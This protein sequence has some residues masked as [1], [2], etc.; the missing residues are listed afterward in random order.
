M[1]RTKPGSEVTVT[2]EILDEAGELIETSDPDEPMEIRLGDD[3]FP[4]T[5]EAALLDQ[6]EGAVVEVTC[7]EGEAFGDPDPEAIVAVP[8]ED[9]PEELE[10]KKGA[11]VGITLEGDGDG[12][13]FE[14]AEMP[15]TVVEVNAEGVILDANHPLAGKPATFRVTVHSIL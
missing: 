8:I 15:A 9:F 7:P 4:P 2:V 14:E 6:P 10:L 11:L 12:D 3:E 13:D 1:K 5:V